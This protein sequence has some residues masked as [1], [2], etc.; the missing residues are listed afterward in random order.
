MEAGLSVGEEVSF[1]SVE[2][3]GGECGWR[4]WVESAGAECGVCWRGG[5]GEG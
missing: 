3:V 4:V 5:G 2:S 1:G